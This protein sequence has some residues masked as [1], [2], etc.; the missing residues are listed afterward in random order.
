MDC[1]EVA[2]GAEFLKKVAPIC[3]EMDETKYAAKQCGSDG[4]FQRSR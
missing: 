2:V 1:N 4:W 3:D